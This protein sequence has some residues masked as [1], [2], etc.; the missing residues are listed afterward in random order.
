MAHQSLCVF[1]FSLS[2]KK[3]RVSPVNCYGGDDQKSPKARW[4]G[5]VKSRPIKAPVRKEDQIQ[6]DDN[7]IK[8]GRERL[9]FFLEKLLKNNLF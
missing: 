8:R 6:M 1:S 4:F 9:N 2:G 5:H 3:L 7:L